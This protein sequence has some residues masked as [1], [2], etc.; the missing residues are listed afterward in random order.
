M[1]NLE[2]RRKAA[3]ALNMITKEHHLG[4]KAIQFN[5]DNPDQWEVPTDWQV[6]ALIDGKAVA[7]IDFLG[8]LAQVAINN[9]YDII[10]NEHLSSFDPIEHGCEI[11]DGYT[12]VS[13]YPFPDAEYEIDCSDVPN[14]HLPERP[15]PRSPTGRA[16]RVICSR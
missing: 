13:E 14:L 15:I 16:P 9:W 8:T 11:D 4:S 2:L 6:K 7:E 12:P 10:R 3:F 5:G 1:G